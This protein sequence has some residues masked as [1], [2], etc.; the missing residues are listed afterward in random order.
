MLTILERV[1]PKT[2]GVEELLAVA[3]FWRLASPRSYLGCV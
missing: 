1:G 3:P 2:L